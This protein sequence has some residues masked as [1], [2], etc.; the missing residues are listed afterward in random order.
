MKNN[1][2]LLKVTLTL[3]L[4]F[5]IIYNISF[6]KL[7]VSY[8]T[9]KIVPVIIA[10]LLAPIIAFIGAFKWQKII[11]HEA[12]GLKF[13]ESLISFLGGMSLGLLTPARVGE[14]G[15]IVFIKQGRLGVLAGIAMVDK[16]I[17]LE[18]TLALGIASAYAFLGFKIAVLLTIAVFT[19]ILFIFY[20]KMFTAP[21]EGAINKFGLQKLFA[22]FLNGMSTIP[23]KTILICLLYRLLASVIDILQFYLL[24]N[25]FSTITLFSVIAV[26]PIIILTNILPLTIGGIGVREG[27]SII[28]LSKYGIPP[29]SAVNASFL[30]FCINT[31]LPGILGTLF[32]TKANYKR[33]KA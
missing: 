10:F 28:L 3:L 23:K 14:F 33:V 13:K 4:I 30:L 26:Y 16:V 1:K 31:L 11:S 12:I 19:G 20:P 7:A 15:R 32:I 25:A 6:D 17:D 21:L 9:I 29:E 24:I 22:N 27:V 2:I 18:V 5:V 8:Q